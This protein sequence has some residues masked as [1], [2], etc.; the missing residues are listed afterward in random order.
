[1]NAPSITTRPSL[2]R[3]F[4]HSLRSGLVHPLLHLLQKHSGS[5][6]VLRPPLAPV[7]TRSVVR[8]PIDSSRLNAMVTDLPA[9]PSVLQDLRSAL[10]RDDASIDEFA[11]RIGHDA[12][13][14]ARTLR[15]ANSAFYG[16]SGRVGNLHAAIGILGLRTLSALL[17]TAAVAGQFT[18]PRCEGFS[19]EDFWRH[20]LAASIAGRAIARHCGLDEDLCHVSALLHDIGRLALATHFT[21]PY[22]MALAHSAATDVPDFEAEQKVLGICHAQVGALVAAHWRFPEAVVLAIA[23][24]HQP[25]AAAGAASVADVVHVCDAMAHGL[26]MGQDDSES[27]PQMSMG[28]WNRL[29]LSPDACL[30]IFNEVESAVEHLSHA[31]TS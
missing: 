25:A 15:L 6:E 4:R 23:S 16:V 22:E 9:L 20:T 19:P 28:A 31:L 27:V 8:C 30:T 18:A 10:R 7:E 21:Q 1:M 29:G 17:T 11:E 26:A 2:S 24:H 14:T 12:A 5:T 3:L 13:L